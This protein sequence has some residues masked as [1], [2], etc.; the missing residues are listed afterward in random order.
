MEQNTI[1]IQHI[2]LECP[3]AEF[4]FN[5]FLLT[6]FIRYRVLNSNAFSP[7]IGPQPLRFTALFFDHVGVTKLLDF[8]SSCVIKNRRKASN[9]KVLKFIDQNSALGCFSDKSLTK[10][11][12]RNT[13][14][15]SL[16][17]MHRRV[18]ASHWLGIR[19]GLLKSAPTSFVLL[20]RC[21]VSFSAKITHDRALDSAL[22]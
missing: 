16:Y 10:K 3:I 1:Q 7:G 21:S 12:P 19:P 11:Q 4:G 18:S 8:K 22:F 5:R 15:Q 13:F 14:L 6:F 2:N 9:I 17:S 20:P